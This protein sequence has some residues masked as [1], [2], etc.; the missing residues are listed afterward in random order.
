MLVSRAFEFK[1]GSIIDL[2]KGACMFVRSILQNA[3]SP[4]R[5]PIRALSP[6]LKGGF[7]S[8]YI[9]L[10]TEDDLWVTQLIEKPTIVQ[11]NMEKDDD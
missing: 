8:F 10:L 11:M 7:T 5:R 6:Y 9:A 4:A 2:A 3:E 1:P